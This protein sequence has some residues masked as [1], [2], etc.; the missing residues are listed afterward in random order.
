[1]KDT[2]FDIIVPTYGRP[3]LLRR[4]LERF[5]T[6]DLPSELNR[7][8]IIE[9]GPRAGAEAVC[10]S[11]ARS[12]P[13]GYLYSSRAGLA[14]A[15]NFGIEASAARFLLFLDDDVN[16]LPGAL[17]AYV[18]AFARHGDRAF[19]G[20]PL[21]PDYVDGPPA[22]WLLELLP[23]SAKGF[24]LGEEERTLDGDR[25]FLGGNLALP[26]G[27]FEE[28]GVFEGP[29]AMGSTGGGGGEEMRLQ[30]RLRARG[31]RGVYVPGAGVQHYVPA[32][33]CD[34]AFVRH[35]Y[36]R[37]GYTLGQTA[38]A[39]ADGK[40]PIGG[41]PLG[42][43][44]SLVI[45]LGRLALAISPRAVKRNKF[46]DLLRVNQRLGKIRGYRGARRRG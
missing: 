8:W 9:N 24:T 21:V 36:W 16:P 13:L 15:R 17:R 44:V 7:I 41:A 20:G 28:V 2:S 39:S 22:D 46:R 18:E 30:S 19:F 43:W 33:R 11:L 38:A 27:A 23:G 40:L 10:N 4:T 34:A 29:S 45:A 5:A 42:Y 12:L 26:R 1:M 32:K 3:W 37:Y 31:Y 35:R 14:Q 25:Y 6:D